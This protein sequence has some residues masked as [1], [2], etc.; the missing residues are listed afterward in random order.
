MILPTF[1]F[2]ETF[3]LN[4]GDIFLINFMGHTSHANSY[5]RD[6]SETFVKNSL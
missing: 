4:L 1:L 3:G 6:D 5:S 2:A